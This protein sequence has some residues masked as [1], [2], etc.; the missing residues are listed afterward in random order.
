MQMSFSSQDSVFFVEWTI[1]PVGELLATLC[2]LV[3]NLQWFLEIHVRA[4]DK[5]KLLTPDAKPLSREGALGFYLW[6]IGL[7]LASLIGA[8]VTGSTFV[9]GLAMVL[10]GL[11]LLTIYF[12][13]QE[14]SN[15]KRLG[16]WAEKN[17]RFA[18]VVTSDSPKWAGHINDNWLIR[19]SGHVSVLNY[20]HKSEWPKNIESESVA[21]F[22]HFRGDHPIV[23]VPRKKGRPAVYRFYA[24]LNAAF[25]G[26]D[27][28]L[29][30][31]EERLFKEYGEWL[32][33]Q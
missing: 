28:S 4:E 24:A 26:D 29:V 3:A 22:T 6:L 9:I 21:R 13:I 1:L 7:L 25:H 32:Q 10:A 19:F 33:S 5:K 2:G 11:T 20:S 15:L 18:I 16:Q 14:R 12:D 17:R 31:M 23:I 30:K 8:V 27:E